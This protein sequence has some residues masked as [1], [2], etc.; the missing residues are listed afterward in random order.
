MA[1]FRP[2]NIFLGKYG[3]KIYKLAAANG[4][5]WNYIIYFGQRDSMAGLGRDRTVVMHLLGDLEGCYRTVVPDNFF[6]SIPLAK[7]LL[8]HDTYLIGTLRSN[9][10]GSGS[11]VAQKRLR[12]GEVYELQN[13]EGVKLIM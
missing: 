10:T 13:K 9:R 11:E 7:H 6:T 4:Y 2:S 5:T 3:V 8:E 1:G 12:R